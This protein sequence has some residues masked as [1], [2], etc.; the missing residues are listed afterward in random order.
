MRAVSEPL[1][2]V[3]AKA[4]ASAKPQTFALARENVLTL[5]IAFSSIYFVACELS[6]GP[7]HLLWLQNK[8]RL[9]KLAHSVC[10]L[11]V[12]GGGSNPNSPV[13]IFHQIFIT[14]F[15]EYLGILCQRAV[16]A[17]EEPHDIRPDL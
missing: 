4:L 13:N 1:S 5:E 15:C 10:S 7:S 3:R 11:A 6:H 17:F 14:L 16:G 8:G 2:A 12:G 9:L